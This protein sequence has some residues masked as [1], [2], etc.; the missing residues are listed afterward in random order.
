MQP[1]TAGT[2]KLQ[3][4]DIFEKNFITFR[5]PF[6]ERIK[7][8]EAGR[9]PEESPNEWVARIRR[10]TVQCEFDNH[11]ETALKDYLYVDL[12]RNMSWIDF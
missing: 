2:K 8:Y 11:L 3:L 9:R 12:V 4:L 7:F 1:S 5:T 10:L 6:T